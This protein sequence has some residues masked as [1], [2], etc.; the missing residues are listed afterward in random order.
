MKSIGRAA[1][2]LS[3]LLSSLALAAAEA[4][5]RRETPYWASVSSGR[6]M[7]RAGPGR[8]YPGTWLYVRA[9][10]PVRVL[11]VYQSWRKVEDPD[12]T[13]GWMLVNLLSDTRTALVRGGEPQRMHERPDPA[14]PVRYR[15]EPGVVGRI[16]RCAGGWCRLDVRGRA[17]FI[18][19]DH[20]WGL[21]R[22]ETIE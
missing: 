12:G 14:S 17:G 20:I 16:S 15:A 1:A 22:G 11:E 18:R 4:Q 7:M 3:V 19:S 2:F 21:G 6:A 9:D 10:L 5:P 8:N 13:T